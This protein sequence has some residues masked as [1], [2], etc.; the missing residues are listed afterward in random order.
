MINQQFFHYLKLLRDKYTEKPQYNLFNVL[1]SDS[2]EVRLHSRFLVDILNPRGSHRHGSTFLNDFLQ[3]LSI[4]LTGDIQVDCEYKNIDILIR[5]QDTAIIIENKI[6]AGDQDKQLL[7]YHEAMLN[8]GYANIYLFYLT[9]DGKDASE[10]SAGSLQN[11]VTN[12]SYADDIHT[13]IHRCTEIAVR[14]APLREAFI[15]YTILIN[16]LTHKVDNMEHVNQLKQ[17]LLTGD[18][19][20]SI[21]E[22]NQA[23]EEIIIDAQVAMWNM[24]GDKMAETFGE[25]SNNSI[26]KHH[27]IRSSVKRYVQAKRNSRYI[28]QEVPL[29]NYPSFNLFIEQNHHLY[30]GIYCEDETNIIKGK[31]LPK[32]K[33]SY[34]DSD[35]YNT[36]WTYPKHKINFRNITDNNVKFLSTPS[37]L[38]KMVDQII[39]EMVQMIEM[40]T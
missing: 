8:E 2:D 11:E 9:L 39:D 35:N 20:L 24:L 25:L 3:R 4:K 31:E 14:D 6:Y 5:N 7:R 18:N 22:I 29:K 13:W 15:Q 16:N 17:L 33:H 38:E 32:R 27:D 19:L 28:I 26:S 10:Q 37:H 23:Y 12:L 30:F 1:R 36:F 21:G 40:Y 34:K